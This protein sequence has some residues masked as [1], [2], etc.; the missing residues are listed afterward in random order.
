DEAPVHTGKL[1]EATDALDITS[2]ADTA[3]KIESLQLRIKNVD[4]VSRKKAFVNYIHLD[5]AWD[6][7]IAEEPA[8][9]PEKNL[10]EPD[11]GLELFRR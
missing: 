4:N 2:F 11:D 3:E 6:W 7:S 9:R 5:V 8:R 10:D 1:K